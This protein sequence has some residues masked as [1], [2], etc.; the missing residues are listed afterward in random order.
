M[1]MN[2]GADDY[3]PKP[4]DQSVLIAKVQALLRR[5][6]DFN[7]NSFALQAAGAVLN[8]EDNTLL[9]NNTIGDID[10]PIFYA[11]GNR[12]FFHLR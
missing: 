7:R 12:D 6:Y 4:F 8:T 2:M 10:S 11:S 9:Y 3:I 1:A 5:A